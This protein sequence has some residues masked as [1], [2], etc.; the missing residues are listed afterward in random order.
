MEAVSVYRL[1]LE[2][3]MRLTVEWIRKDENTSADQLSRLED[4]YDYMLDPACFNYIDTFWGP[5]TIERFASLKTKQLER[6]CSRYRNPGWVATDG[7]SV[8]WSHEVDWLFPPPYLEPHVLRY[9]SVGREYGTLVVP[10]WHSASWW[11]L[12]VEKGGSWKSFISQSIQIQRYKGIFLSGSASSDIFTAGVPSFLPSP[13]WHSN[14]VLTA[15][16]EHYSW[17]NY[18][19]EVCFGPRFL[20]L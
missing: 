20:L 3:G 7:F 8:S 15:I 9:T 4:S 11:P 5:H 10:E 19:D 14:F 12:L 16:A 2:L 6:Y 1:C 13:F 18:Y 17:W